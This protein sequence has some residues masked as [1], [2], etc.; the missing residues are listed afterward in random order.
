[1]DIKNPIDSRVT[2]TLHRAEYLVAFALTIG[3]ILWHISAIRWGPA[4][5]LFL[6]IDLIG[7]VPGA[8]AFRRSKDGRISKVYYVLYNTMHSLITCGAVAVLWAWLVRPEWALLAI[9][10]HVFGDRGVFGNFYKPFGLPFEP[11]ASPHVGRVSK[12]LE[13]RAAAAGPAPAPIDEVAPTAAV[14]T[15]P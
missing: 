15:T 4:I 11:V 12:M 13:A 6:Y 1:M 9:A 10:F 2:F 7:Y 8:I 5:G 14:G 3:L